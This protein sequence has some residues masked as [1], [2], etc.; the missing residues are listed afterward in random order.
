MTGRA[1]SRP[2]R[3]DGYE[4]VS[5]LGGGGF[6]DVFLYRQAR[7]HRQ[8]AV[9]VLLAES[10]G[11]RR[12]FAAEAD[13]MAA[14]STHPAIVTIH[15]AEVAE[16]GRPCIVMEYCP[17]PNYGTRF[18]TERIAVDEALR[19][20]VMIAGALETAH[21]AGIL[22]RDIKPANILVTE[23]NRPALTDFGIAI[24]TCEGSDL[25]DSSGMS[26]P[27]SPPEFFADPPRA[28]VRSDVFSLAATVYSLLA[29]RTPFELPSRRGTAADLIHR[30]GSLPLP[31][32]ERPDAPASLHRVLA[33]AMAKD[34]AARYDTALALGR[35]LQQVEAELALPVTPMDV[36]E[37]RSLPSIADHPEPDEMDAHTRI[38]SITSIAP[39]AGATPVRRLDPL[40][41]VASAPGEP[42]PS[43]R[44]QPVPEDTA[45]TVLRP[46]PGAHAIPDEDP[47]PPHRGGLPA[48]LLLTLAALAVVALGIGAVVGVRAAF[49]APRADPTPTVS[50][51]PA[52]IDGGAPPD[53]P[54]GIVIERIDMPGAQIDKA[55]IHWDRPAGFTAQDSY[56]VRWTHL[57]EGYERY[58][59]PHE[60]SGRE[61][62]VMDAPP[63]H[64]QLCV[65]ITVVTESGAPG[66]AAEQCG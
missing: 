30:I 55:R 62:L 41:A 5:L 59:E 14:M 58:G 24:A 13:V 6:A 65:E 12:Q 10:E 17:R 31:P 4:Y 51:A 47:V 11:V 18:R 1:P 40:D 3:L 57:Q 22:H 19:V 28:D 33:V 52:E 36:L 38:R 35:A 45:R 64:D 39:E 25:E 42:A 27:W 16:D 44:A 26:I 46:V 7:P 43:D 15:Q 37:D 2:P 54:T 50:T 53:P 49:P 66:E 9:K 61:S 32:L 60:V 63:H 56:R 34:P 29:G 20:G 8:V 21:R 23:Y 48:W